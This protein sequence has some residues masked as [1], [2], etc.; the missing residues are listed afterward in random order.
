MS[1]NIITAIIAGSVSIIISGIAGI[2]TIIKNKKRFDDLKKELITK[3]KTEDFITARIKFLDDYREFHPILVENLNGNSEDKTKALQ[4]LIDF[5]AEKAKDYYMRNRA[6]LK[7]K[8]LENLLTKINALFDSKTLNNKESNERSNLG[9][10][11]LSF[12]KKLNE[13]SLK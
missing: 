2:Y 5:F 10:N 9:T 11:L 8:E 3:S 12:V 7:S 4:S 13:Q 1:E 6:F